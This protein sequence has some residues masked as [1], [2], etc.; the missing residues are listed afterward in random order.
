MQKI[1]VLGAGMV[2]GPLV[3]YLLENQYGLTVTSLK[4][5]DAV[6]LVGDS[7]HGRAMTLDLSDG[8]ALSALVAAHDL[9]ISLVPYSYHSLVANHCLD[10]GQSQQE[11]ADLQRRLR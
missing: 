5:E 11:Q 9:V 1:L 4:L 7:E 10:K 3:S 8:E 2:A 6:K